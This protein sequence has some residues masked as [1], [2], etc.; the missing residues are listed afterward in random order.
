MLADIVKFPFRAVRGALRRALK[1]SPSA[2]GAHSRSAPTPVDNPPRPAPTAAATSAAPVAPKAE[3]KAP[4]TAKPEA[5]P[6]SV[7][8]S[9]TPNP[10][11]RKFT[12]SVP[13]APGASLSFASVAEAGDHAL[14]RTLLE[15][16]GVL[17]VFISEDFVTVTKKP[18]ADWPE[19]MQVLEGVIGEIADEMQAARAG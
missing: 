6:V 19:L 2:A 9:D 12:C 18:K 8:I 1:V 11:A 13:L 14:A 17:T 16:D 4:K 7:T 3:V 15:F 5:P 10:D